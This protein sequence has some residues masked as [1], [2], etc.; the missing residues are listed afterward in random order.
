M[1]IKSI[2][3]F[4]NVFVA[5][6]VL[7]IIVTSIMTKP[8]AKNK[9]I[10]IRFI[11][12]LVVGNFYIINI[13]FILSFINMYNRLA[14]II[15]ILFTS[16]LI[17][18]ILDK[19][20]AKSIYL[21][22][23]TTI[24][25]L[26]Y[27]EYAIKLFL[28]RK[29]LNIRLSIKSFCKE[30]FNGNKLELIIFLLIMCYNIYYYNYNNVNFVSFGAPDEEVHLFWIQSQ[31]RGN[32]FPSG[33]YPHGFHNV[34]SAV[35]V[36]FGFNAVTVLN[37]FGVVSTVLIMSM[38]YVG[39]RK[40]LKSKY[41]A[42]FGFLIY[43]LANIYNFE[44]IYRFQFSIP[45]EYGMIVLMPMVIFLFQYLKDK[46]MSDLILFGMCFSLT[47]SIHFYLTIIALFLCLSVGIVY[48]YRIIK[49]K[50]LIKLL[51]CG[52][53]STIIAI[54]PLAA[55]LA[56]GHEMEQSMNWAVRVIQ[57]KEY[58]S[59][60]DNDN[61]N[62]NKLE[63]TNYI[64]NWDNFLVDTEEEITKHV[65]IDIRVMYAFMMLI[66]LAILNNILFIVLRSKKE[67]NLYQL[68]FALYAL[69]LIFLMLGRP[70]NIPTLMESKR[71]A[72]FFAYFS[73]I[74]IAMPIEVLYGVFFIIKNKKICSWVTFISIP[75]SLV[76]MIKLGAIRPLLP[77]YYFQTKGAMLVDCNIME[78]FSDFSWTIVAPVNDISVIM[79]N[80]YHYELSDFILKQENWNEDKEIKI[81]TKYV[82]V[83]IEKKPIINYGYYF[84]QDDIGIVNR[85]MVTYEDAL[86]P[87]KKEE[88]DNCCYKEDRQILM[89]KA[90]YWAKEYRKY[91]SKE[92]SVY[93]EDDEIIVYKIE[94][95]E[96][97]LNNFAIDYEANEEK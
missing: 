71:V 90:Y 13:V 20:D 64:F 59:D 76:I 32:I 75:V 27:G 87:L 14:L 70:L 7:I 1:H 5:Y 81:P 95:N 43:S 2:I 17:R 3:D 85:E 63:E 50:L 80:G 24:K 91:F 41:A 23:K 97:A 77:F 6:F 96:Y 72:I 12:Y 78:K 58:E 42:L 44:A 61:G 15:T 89:S 45:Q 84:Y 68:S 9:N 10:F 26:L 21:D 8:I 79:N 25:H 33:V 66:V 67:E 57:G 88:K 74:L 30:F 46:R 55:G 28:Q 19:E 11:L 39:L 34:L 37:S 53:L 18:I 49:E 93:Y 94:Q 73:P 4:I 29:F 16:I 36:F 62:E 83:Y 86:K 22:C 92:M 35:T 52:V 82:F 69:L 47:I 56:M 48:L 54:A 40:V 60:N 38:L 31:I 51:L 65:L